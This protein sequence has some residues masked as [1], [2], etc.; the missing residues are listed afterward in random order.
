MQTSFGNHGDMVYKSAHECV[1]CVQYSEPDCDSNKLS[2][3]DKYYHWAK[4]VFDFPFFDCVALIM[5]DDNH[6]NCLVKRLI[7]Q[8][9]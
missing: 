6:Q 8:S 2:T 7:C 4:F 3:S 9:I 1:S 5:K